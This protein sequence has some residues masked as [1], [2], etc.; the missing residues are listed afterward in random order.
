MPLPKSDNA[1]NEDKEEGQVEKDKHRWDAADLEKVTDFHEDKDEMNEVSKESIGKLQSKT[2][3]EAKKIVIR[4]ED[5][6]VIVD[7]LEVPR[8]IAERKL[9]KHE[10]NLKSALRDLMGFS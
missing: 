5:V 2:Q 10:G 4:K 1:A 6:Q 8:S 9:I 7:E 3:A